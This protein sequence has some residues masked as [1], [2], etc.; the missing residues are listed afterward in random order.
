MQAG[1]Q[2]PEHVRATASEGQPRAT[3]VDVRRRARP[4]PYVKEHKT[5]ARKSAPVKQAPKA[6]APSATVASTT[7][8]RN[9]PIPKVASAPAKAAA[10][11]AAPAP[12]AITHD[13]IAR[14]AYEISC[15]PGCG[16]EFDNWVRAER[17]L[18]GA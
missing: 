15:G 17:E 1:I 13:M 8:V 12:K 9:S 6:T 7:A 14:K 10:A 3:G 11:I 4:I 18:R 2:P 16:S 5:M